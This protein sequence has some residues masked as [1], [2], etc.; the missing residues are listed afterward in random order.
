M[1]KRWLIALLLL[2]LLAIHP[3]RLIAGDKLV[4]FFENQDTTD[5]IEKANTL[6]KN[7]APDEALKLAK[8]SV[9]HCFEK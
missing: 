2:A 9:S 4:E 3:D 5:L 6:F 8:K 7:G 1:I